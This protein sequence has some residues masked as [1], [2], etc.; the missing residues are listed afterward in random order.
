[1]SLLGFISLVWLKDQFV[2]GDN[3]NWL[4]AD[5]DNAKKVEQEEKIRIL[6]L[7]KETISMATTFS[8][9]SQNALERQ[10]LNRD[11][12]RLEATIDVSILYIKAFIH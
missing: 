3:P 4:V 1:M 11:L 5:F 7:K 12:K 8:R 2:T 6:N 9:T 10:N